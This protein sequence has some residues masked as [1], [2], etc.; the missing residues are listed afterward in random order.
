MHDEHRCKNLQS[1]TGKLIATAH[2]KA[3]PSRSSRL[4]PG[5][6]RLLQPTQVYKHNSPH[7]RTKDKNHMIISIDAEKP[8]INFNSPLF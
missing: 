7:N 3:Y 5:D 8:S 6:A 2:Q 1:N 4:Y